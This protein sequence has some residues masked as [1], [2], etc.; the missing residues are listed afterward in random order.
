MES[1]LAGPADCMSVASCL[2]SNLGTCHVHTVCIYLLQ[3]QQSSLRSKQGGLKLSGSLDRSL[4]WRPSSIPSL[5]IAR[6]L[7]YIYGTFSMCV[8]CGTICAYGVYRGCP[9]RWNGLASQTTYLW[10]SLYQLKVSKPACI[11]IMFSNSSFTPAAWITYLHYVI[12]TN[13]GEIS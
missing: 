10:T 11:H 13:I 3:P 5:V 12:S 1:R 7:C 9:W 4:P 2:N 8:Q 6:M